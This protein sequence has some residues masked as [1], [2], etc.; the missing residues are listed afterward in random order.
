VVNKTKPK[1]ALL[2]TLLAIFCMT[3]L[4]ASVA[5]ASAAQLWDLIIAVKLQREQIKINDRPVIFGTV[6]NHAMK[7]VAGAD[8]RIS[9]ANEAVYTKTDSEGNFQY[10]FG[11]QTTPGLFAVNILAKSGSQIGLAKTSIR[12][13]D[14]QPSF[15]EIYY[16]SS[17]IFENQTFPGSQ[18]AEIQLRQYQK[19]LAEQNKLKQKQIEN[20]AK[21]LE[22]KEKQDASKQAIENILLQRQVGAGVFSDKDYQR[23]ISGV[24]PRVKD[25]ISAQL[26]YTKQVFTE[27]QAAMKA[28][29]DNG[30]SLEEARKAYF[31][32]LAITRDQLISVNDVNNTESHSKIKLKDPTK[33]NSKKVKGLT[34][35]KN[36]K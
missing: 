7:P 13:G 31:E 14:A 5:T 2:K 26:N 11:N 12:I 34:Y 25:A 23:Y 15:N 27:A 10:E 30:G 9:F 18:Y 22:L 28:V 35:N 6:V 29:L 20:E 24:D 36:L 19:F 8:I 4:L 17:K 3:I 32:K 21:R 33:I 1:L 16:N